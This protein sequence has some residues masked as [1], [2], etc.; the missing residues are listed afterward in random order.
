MFQLCGTDALGPLTGT[1]KQGNES[2]GSAKSEKFFNCLNEGLFLMRTYVEWYC[3]LFYSLY[4]LSMYEFRL[5]TSI[6][7]L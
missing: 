6:L 1:Y 2:L 3:V 4:D 7:P 5:N